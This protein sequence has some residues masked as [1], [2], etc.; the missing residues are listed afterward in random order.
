MGRVGG[1]IEVGGGRGL[2]NFEPLIGTCFASSFAFDNNQW[3]VN[4]FAAYF[5]SYS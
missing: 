4:L 2:Q 5:L 3:T 1:R